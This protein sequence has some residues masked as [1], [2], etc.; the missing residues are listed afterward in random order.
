[1]PNSTCIK[2]GSPAEAL[3]VP[4]VSH[5]TRKIVGWG[6]VPFDV[7]LDGRLRHLDVRVYAILSASR[8]GQIAGIGTRLIGKYAHASQRHV[9]YSLK[10]LVSCGH[11]E[12]LPTKRGYRA[13][14]RLLSACF[15]RQEPASEAA[16]KPA[17]SLITC[18]NCKQSCG[19]LLRTGWCRRCASSMRVAKIADERIAAATGQA[20]PTL[21]KPPSAGMQRRTPS[22][23]Q[24][25]ADWARIQQERETA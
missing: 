21:E 6:M 5:S 12:I 14:Y 10:R 7:L 3:V 16:A 4:Q 2:R 23:R 11:V 15:T 8:R 24:A 17:K 18:P 9:V 13:R 19:G 25:A 20:P 22:A 1:M